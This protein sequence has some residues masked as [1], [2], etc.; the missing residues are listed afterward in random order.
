MSRLILSKG[1]VL[2]VDHGLGKEQPRRAIANEREAISHSE[3]VD[4]GASRKA[5][6]R[7]RVARQSAI[8][9]NS[10]TNQRSDCC[11]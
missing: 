3:P 4:D 11:T 7:S 1:A 2:N 8:R 9:W 5:M 6:T 10:S